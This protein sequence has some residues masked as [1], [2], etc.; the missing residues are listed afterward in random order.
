MPKLASES[1]LRENQNIG[2][3]ML[4]PVGIELRPLIFS[5]WFQVKHSPFWTKLTF[6]CK[7]ETLGPLYNHAL[8]IL[9]ESSKSKNQVV[10]EQ[11]FKDHLT[12]TYQA[13]PER[14][15][16]DLESEVM[17]GLASIPTVGFIL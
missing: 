2:W 14:I 9:T 12:S 15:V 1:L 11:K 17:R 3:K 7:T 4:P 13:S 10:H 8:L 5:L 6:A 16:L